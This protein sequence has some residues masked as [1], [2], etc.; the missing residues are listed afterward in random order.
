MYTFSINQ[1]PN[2]KQVCNEGRKTEG[3]GVYT[4][5]G[6]ARWLSGGPSRGGD[7][8]GGGGGPNKTTRSLVRNTA[9]WQYIAVRFVKKKL[10][11]GGGTIIFFAI[12]TTLI[13]S[14]DIPYLLLAHAYLL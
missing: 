10:V 11:L 6:T 13:I 14:A 3:G 1:H 9:S 5:G 7:G 4:K 2:I 12:S 8:G